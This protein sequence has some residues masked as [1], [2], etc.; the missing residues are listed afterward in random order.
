[1]SRLRSFRSGLGSLA[2]KRRAEREL[3]EEL[4]G[5]L[6]ASVEEKMRRGMSAEQ[7]RRRAKV[8]MGSTNAVKH[9]VWSSRWEAWV[10]SRVQDVKIAVRS[11]LKSPGFTAVALLSLALGI[12]ANTSIFTLINAAMLRPLPVAHAEELV[13][14]GQGA[15]EG[16]SNGLPDGEVE[17]FSHPFYRIFQAKTDV[18]ASVAA[19]LSMQMEPHASVDGGGWEMLHT[20]L[21][22]GGYFSTL[23]VKPVLGRTIMEADDRAAGAGPVA[24]LS[25][26]YFRRRFDG[27]RGAIGKAIRIRDKDYTIVGVAEPGFGGI[28]VGH[29]ADV[30]IPL[31]MQKDLSPG[32]NGYDDK[33]WQSLYLFGR[34]KPGV[35]MTQAQAS[36][37]LLFHQ[38]LR[39]EY[40]GNPPSQKELTAIS[41]AGFNLY[42]LAAGISELRHQYELPLEILM[43]IVGLVLLIACANLGNMLLARSVAR[44]REVAVRMALGASRGRLVTQLVTE[45]AVLALTGAALGVVLAWIV[46]PLLLRMAT[47][48]PEAMPL[49]VHPDMRVLGFTLAVTVVTAL[50]FGVAPALR[51]T[52]LELTPTLKEGRGIAA[53]SRGIVARGMIAGQIAL[54]I[55]LMSVAGLFVRSMLKLSSI[56]TG[57]DVHNLLLV[58]MDPSAASLPEAAETPTEQRIEEAVRMVPGVQ[59]AGIGFYT[60][61]QGGWTDLALFQGTQRT[62]GNGSEVAYNIIGN[63]YLRAMAIPL[64]AG[65]GFTRQDTKTAPKVALINE[66]MQRKFFPNGESAIGKHFGFGDDA[67]KSGEIEVVGVVKDAKY[68][69]LVENPRMAAYFPM[70]QNPGFYGNLVVR[71]SGGAEGVIAGVR[72]AIAGV[73][74]NIA[75]DHISPMQQQI[76]LAMARTTLVSR[77]SAFFGVLAVGLACL[78]IYGLLAYSVARR[79]NEIGVRLALGARTESVLWLVLRESLVLLAVGVAAGIPIALASTGVLRKLLYQ[80]SPSDPATLAGAALVVAVMTVVAAWVPARRAAKVDP[81]VALRCE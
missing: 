33:L 69:S 43:G 25:Y 68:F 29:P 75:I 16:S 41:H 77:L 36:T 49:D 6:A 14:F 71:Y 55:L 2:D 8:E 17:L 66:T 65:R 47:P 10:D 73:N 1:M 32:W 46:S 21:V 67:A 27:D 56:D 22:S 79:T 54:S 51:A 61:A 58:E 42:S 31:S 12:G 24:V 59:S 37:D 80:L 9:Q 3:D 39:S 74:P 23:G 18:Y 38:I 45:A 48:G 28:K 19:V 70:A 34:L 30:W 26:A 13:L 72:R 15:A 64:I 7:A 5:F 20:D 60:F 11:L 50:L 81:M 57:F 78:G 76:E 53:P 35:T 52:K 44:A 40:V 62:Q 4:A 63:D